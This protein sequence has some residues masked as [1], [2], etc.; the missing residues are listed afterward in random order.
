M[1]NAHTSDPES[2]D[3]FPPLRQLMAASVCDMMDTLSRLVHE[4]INASVEMNDVAAYEIARHSQRAG[5]WLVRAASRAPCAVD[6]CDITLHM[7]ALAAAVRV[8]SMDHYP[9]RL[10]L[11]AAHAHH[12]GQALEQWF[13]EHTNTP[14][15][16]PAPESPPYTIQPELTLAPLR[17]PTRLPMPRPESPPPLRPPTRL[18]MPMHGVPNVVRD[19]S[20][21]QRNFV[22]M[23]WAVQSHG[24]LT[25]AM[26]TVPPAM[27]VTV[28][29]YPGCNTSSPGTY[30][31]LKHQ[32]DIND[33]VNESL[34]VMG[35]SVYSRTY[36]AGESMPDMRQSFRTDYKVRGVFQA[37]LPRN[38][39]CKTYDPQHWRQAERLLQPQ[40]QV[41]PDVLDFAR[42]RN[43]PQARPDGDAVVLSDALRTWPPGVYVVS[44]C[45][46]WSSGVTDIQKQLI[47]AREQ[48]LDVGNACE[49]Y[50]YHDRAKKWDESW[51]R[52]QSIAHRD[53][54]MDASRHGVDAS[55]RNARFGH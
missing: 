39:L 5:D 3:I 43:A 17:P 42:R 31:L 41:G 15:S 36:T 53:A 20:Q 25:G 19:P 46:A 30:Q 7:H 26:F 52:V 12:A 24:C 29:A 9:V 4:L 6:K 45:R 33:L 13:N 1:R 49:A 40:F 37:P 38:Y 11:L 51:S 54:V 48:R 2:S 28:L 16:V 23:T 34:R 18:P 22:S 55:P 21:T 10:K 35:R 50:S 14:A 8:A 27:K 32:H 47:L 44:G